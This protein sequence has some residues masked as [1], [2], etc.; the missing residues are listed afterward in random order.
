LEAP[1]L[2]TGISQPLPDAKFV[3]FPVESAAICFGSINAL[4]DKT[5]FLLQM[6]IPV[7]FAH[8]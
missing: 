1:I 3:A 5:V 8:R 2:Q 6:Q 4:V 7:T